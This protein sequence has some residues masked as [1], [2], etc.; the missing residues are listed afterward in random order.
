M[1]ATTG[2]RVD[3]DGVRGLAE[4]RREQFDDLGEH[5]RVVLG[6]RGRRG[7]VPVGALVCGM[8]GHTVRLA[9][10]GSVPVRRV[11]SVE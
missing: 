1:T 4:R 6:P 7:L 2:G 5:D 10:I 8:L 3:H 9:A 11:D